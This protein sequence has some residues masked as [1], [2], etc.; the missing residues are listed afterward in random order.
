MTTAHQHKVEE[1]DNWV[2]GETTA[3]V[4]CVCGA[5]GSVPVHSDDGSVAGDVE[6]N[7]EEA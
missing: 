4:R 2:D 7:D 6:W 1:R 3:N 5:T